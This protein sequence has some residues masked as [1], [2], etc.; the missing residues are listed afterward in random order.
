MDVL[1]GVVK[2]VT[3]NLPTPIRDI[4]INILGPKCYANIILN[5]DLTDTACLKL[6]VSKALGIGI[7]GVSA[8]VKLPQLYNLVHSKSASGISLLSYLLETAA[9]VITL[10][11]NARMGN[12]FSTY[13]ENAFIAVQNVAIASLVLHYGGQSTGAAVFIA[14]LAAAAYAL[15]APGVI[16][17]NTMS[18]LQAGAGVL[19]IAS[20]VP[21]IATI[22]REGSTGQ[23]SS[24]AV[25][26]FLFGSLS[27]IF[28]TLQEVN[29]PVILYGYIAGFALNLV[30]AGQVLYYWN[31]P[32]KSSAKKNI[33]KI[34]VQNEKAESIPLE[35]PSRKGPTTRRR[36]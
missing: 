32:A 10:A 4:G 13:G 8:I 19:G 35:A 34:R 24:F 29:D 12:P 23:L 30:L 7:V 22:W 26:N 5:V 16:D 14:G 18:M 6:A 2:P 1:R 27:R 15:F 31:T 25:F 28:T 3:Q 36:A 21:Q 11:Y 17:M 20:K 33:P 9:Y